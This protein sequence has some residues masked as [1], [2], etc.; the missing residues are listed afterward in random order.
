MQLK[1]T[2]YKTIEKKPLVSICIPTYNGEKFIK[3]TVESI[4]AQTYTN[5]EVVISDNKSTDST[6]EIVKK[7][8]S[9]TDVSYKIHSQNP[10]GIGDNWNNCIKQ[11]SGKY[12]KFLFQDDILER[13]CVSEMVSLAESNQEI[14]LVY[15]KRKILVNDSDDF[16]SWLTRFKNLHTHWDSNITDF[17]VCSGRKYM[18]DKNFL[19]E[20][21]N[22][23]AEP[24]ATLIRK[25]CFDKIGSFRNDLK[26]VLDIELFHR[27]MI[28]YD[29]GF[30]DQ[31]L[32]S[33]R[34]HK[35]QA[36]QVNN[37]LKINDYSILDEITYQKFYK[38]LALSNKFK[39]LKLHHPVFIF[40][41]KLINKFH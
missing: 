30:I 35:N 12:I 1:K 32:V 25:E 37:N 14:G 29:I 6:L 2:K 22:K 10:N 40:L 38:Y 8:L 5:F 39:L 19:N 21:L 23:I 27:I 13:N 28:S 31:E 26:Q 7:I 24:S 4:L 18:K 34:L 11:S 41:T 16:S 36:S 3:E 9:E 20:P 17:S 15:S 33:F